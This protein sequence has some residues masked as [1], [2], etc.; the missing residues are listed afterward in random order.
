MPPGQQLRA[1]LVFAPQRLGGG[2]GADSRARQHAQPVR[3]LPVQPCRHARGLLLS[4][5][6]QRALQVFIAFAGLFR[7]GMPPQDQVHHVLAAKGAAPDGP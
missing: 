2:L 1:Q 3:Q 7:L 6:R 4:P 5:G